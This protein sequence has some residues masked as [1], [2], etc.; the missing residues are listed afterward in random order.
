MKIT[1]GQLKRII[2]EEYAVVYG[3]KKPAAK[4]TRRLTP[5]QRQIV[6]A[7]KKK[8]ILAEVKRNYACDQVLEEGLPKFLK[9]L[10]GMFSKGMEQASKIKNAMAEEWNEL[11]EKIDADEKAM[12]AFKAEIKDGVSTIKDDI[13]RSVRGYKTFK[14]IVDNLPE[15]E[16]E[17]KTQELY[18]AALA[19]FKSAIAAA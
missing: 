13:E 10:G 12:E 2:A 1:K 18:A 4:R 8:A 16:K 11:G 15:E 17:Q 19:L 7:K 6:E 3:A 14:D 9:Q 5:K